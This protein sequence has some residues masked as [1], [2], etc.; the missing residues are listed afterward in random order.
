MK[1]RTYQIEVLRTLQRDMS[2]IELIANVGFGLMGEL[3]E[4]VDYIKK[5]IFHKHGIDKKVLM[6]E[7]GDL[8]W[9]VFAFGLM[10]DIDMESV[11]RKNVEK[12]QARY[13]NGFTFEDSKARIDKETK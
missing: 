11:A 8:L 10:F 7:L 13:P 9:Y 5:G 3:G 6:E 2:R 1:I 12:L 4:I